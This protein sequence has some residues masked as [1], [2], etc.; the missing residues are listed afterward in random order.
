MIDVLT[1]LALAIFTT[2]DTESKFV[3]TGLD[4]ELADKYYHLSKAIAA[5][6]EAL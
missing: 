1:A 5:M 4:K 2:T 3:S 6:I